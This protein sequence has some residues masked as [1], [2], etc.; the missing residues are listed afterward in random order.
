MA[1]PNSYDRGR[2]G[3][4]RPQS[5]PPPKLSEIRYFTEKGALRAEL[6]D[7][8]A[9]QVAQT[10]A[11]RIKASQLRRFYGDALALRRRFEQKM[12]GRPAEERQQIFEEILPE[13]KMLKAKTF[14]A[15]Q[16]SVKICPKEMKD[17]IDQ[18]V[19]SVKTWQ[20]FL[21]FCKHFEAVVAYHKYLSNE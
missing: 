3:S 6:L 2:S 12:V 18:H 7:E 13:F 11:Q 5:A 17:F 20:D 21:G 16:R 1:G 9:Y 15:C 19:R 8:E 10:L 4:Q 14:Y